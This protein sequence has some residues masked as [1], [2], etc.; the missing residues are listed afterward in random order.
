MTRSRRRGLGWAICI[1]VVGTVIVGSAAAYFVRSNLPAELTRSDVVGTWVDSDGGPGVA[2]F[3]EDGTA[4]IRDIPGGNPAAGQ[5]TWSL[6]YFQ[7]STVGVDVGG[8]GF[9]LSSK[10]DNFRT[11]LVIYSGDPDDPKAEHR[12][13]RQS[14]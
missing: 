9:D 2:V 12:F 8:R 7:G 14:G 3:R 4:V 1:L 13:V 10:W 5:G 6:S 11:V